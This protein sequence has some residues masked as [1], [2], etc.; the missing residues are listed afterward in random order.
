MKN[1]LLAILRIGL[2]FVM[3]WPF[4]DKTFGL[5]FSTTAE[6]AWINGGTPTMGFLKG[7]SG[8]LASFYNGMAGSPLVDWLFMLGLLLI[9]LSLILGI[10]MYVAGHSGA[11]MM[12]LMYGASLPIKTNPFIDDHLV[13][14]FLFLYLAYA[15]AGDVFGLG[16][17]WGNQKLVKSHGWLK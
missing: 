2:G 12:L 10:G 4:L 6:K 17:K 16:K 1:K 5:G 7:V 11:L 8:P 14:A 9:G 15:G 3:L 13:Y